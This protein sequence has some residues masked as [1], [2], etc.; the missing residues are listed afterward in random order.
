MDMFTKYVEVVPMPNQEAV[1]VAK[2]LVEAVVVHYG[3]PLQILTDQGR[4]FEGQVFTEM[5]RVLEVD[6]VRTSTYHPQCN[7]MIER[8]HRTLNAM[9]GKVVEESQRNWDLCCRTSPLL[10]E[11]PPTV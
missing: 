1:T 3:T 9:L 4:N 6:K 10:T 11:L 2:A 8:F 5:C 7:W